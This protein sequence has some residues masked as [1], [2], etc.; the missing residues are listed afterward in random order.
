[1]GDLYEW[2][3]VEHQSRRSEQPF[4]VFIDKFMH[5]SYLFFDCSYIF[6]K[7]KCLVRFFFLFCF[8]FASITDQA[9]LEPY[10]SHVTHHQHQI[11]P[12][13]LFRTILSPRCLKTTLSDPLL[14]LY[15][16]PAH[17]RSLL[18]HCLYKLTQLLNLQT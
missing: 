16:N 1:M 14:C 11:E 13:L 5:L 12:K 6:N 8:N 4:H 7:K 3:V 15:R 9:C 2:V 18:S 10:P 17:T